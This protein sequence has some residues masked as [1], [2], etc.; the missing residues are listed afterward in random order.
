MQLDFWTL[1]LQTLNAVVLLW[2]LSRF[3]FKPVA[4]MLKTRRDATDRLLAEAETAKRAAEAAKAEAEDGVA[5]LAAERNAL[6]AKA[7]TEAEAA[8]Q[9]IAARGAS[10]ASALKA[11]AEQEI[12]ALRKSR[13]AELRQ[14]VTELAAEATARL[15]SRLPSP[16]SDASFIDSLGEGI[17]RLPE[18][19]RKSIGSVRPTVL[20][21]V[22]NGL[23]GE[24]QARLRGVVEEAVGRRVDLDIKRDPSLLAG[25]E[26]EAEHAIVRD[27]FRSDLD[28]LV[29]EMTRDV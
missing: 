6:I 8:R 24:E 1:G 20:V 15:F 11:A 9:A 17:R 19:T 3:F 21:S 29:T 2:I 26:L 4:A 27:S 22:A 23:S 7:E 18:E 5:R 10:E 14:Q 16:V 12:A 25:L 28:R 13:E